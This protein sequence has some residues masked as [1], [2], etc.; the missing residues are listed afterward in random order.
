MKAPVI[1]RIVRQCLPALVL[2]AM[3]TTLLCDCP[4]R[5]MTRS[6]IVIGTALPLTGALSGPGRE[7]KWAY[8]EAV[9]D[10]NA[11][12]GILVKEYG[13]KLPVKLII[14]DDESDAS[15]TVK[16]V[17]RLIKIYNVDML[18]SG[19]AG[20]GSVIPACVTAEKHKKYCHASISWVAPWLKHKFQWSTLFFFDL[21]QG[22]AVPFQLWNSMPNDQRPKKPALL[23]EDTADGHIFADRFQSISQKYGYDCTLF[24]K[25][26]VGA[27][28]YS[29]QL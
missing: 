28:D 29:A 19:Y 7:Q 18:L 5:A 13:K 20:S 10:V 15:K 4:A 2:V 16:A 17:E 22:I 21:E 27:R 9:K 23:V 1:T 3:A 26:T 12:G 11:K 24:E 8:E 25:L 6:E 14:E